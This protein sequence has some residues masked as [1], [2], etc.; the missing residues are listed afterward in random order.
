MKHAGIRNWL[1]L[2]LLGLAS[3]GAWG[4][5]VPSPDVPHT[6]WNSMQ[7][8][9]NR[10]AAEADARRRAAWVI[11]PTE[12]QLT[13]PVQAVNLSQQVAKVCARCT[14]TADN[15]LT[16][17]GT[18]M[19]ADNAKTQQACVGTVGTA[20]DTTVNLTF[21]WAPDGVPLTPDGASAPFTYF[22]DLLLENR[23]GTV[24]DP[25]TAGPEWSRAANDQPKNLKSNG[26]F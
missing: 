2:A 12:V 21:T 19:R 17:P 23:D 18:S 1:A 7:A 20:V 6:D 4:F 22:C 5:E 10:E 25:A 14:V 16:L 26:R 3:G 9:A 13:V 8:A 11:K 15:Y 24:S